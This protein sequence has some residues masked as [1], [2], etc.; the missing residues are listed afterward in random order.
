MF[1]CSNEP[2]YSFYNWIDWKVPV[3]QRKQGGQ[4]R[5]VV[6]WHPATTPAAATT[7]PMK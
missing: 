2:H 3:N 6:A 7:Q 1:F 5:D 4:F